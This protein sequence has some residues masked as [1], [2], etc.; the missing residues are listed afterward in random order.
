[1]QELK[2]KK[3]FE[4]QRDQLINQQFNVENLA[5]QQEQADITLTAVQAMQAGKEKLKATGVTAESVEQLTD[6]LQEQKQQMDEVNEALAAMNMGIG[7]GIEDD[8][9]EAEY[10]RM[11]EEAA[12]E[13]LMQG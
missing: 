7:A 1:M 8:D 4:Q 11:Q 12:A 10:A 6:E 9:L 13:K 2:R 5:M 3:M